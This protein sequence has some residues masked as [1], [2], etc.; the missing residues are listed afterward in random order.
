MRKTVT[1][2]R[3]RYKNKSKNSFHLVAEESGSDTRI[4]DIREH[5]LNTFQALRAVL[6][7]QA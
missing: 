1:Q 7:Q 2:R 6:S 3:E 4:K 5:I